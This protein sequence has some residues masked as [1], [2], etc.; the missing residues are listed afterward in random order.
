MKLG[1]K[2]ARPFGRA[3]F[4][5][6]PKEHTMTPLELETLINQPKMKTITKTQ[7]SAADA[8]I[9][10]HVDLAAAIDL[11]QD[12]LDNLTC[13]DDAGWSDVSEHARIA[14]AAR[15]MLDRQPDQG[16]EA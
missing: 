5:L 16:R 13:P 12:A 11:L 9:S 8:M 14:D 1:G 3:S 6:Q 2:R 15:N 10:Q 4:K 7:L